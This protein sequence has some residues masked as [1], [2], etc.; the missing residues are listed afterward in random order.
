MKNARPQR[1]SLVFVVGNND[2][3]NFHDFR[4]PAAA[5]TRRGVV[6]GLADIRNRRK[7]H[8][9]TVA[10]DGTTPM[11]CVFHFQTLDAPTNSHD[12]IPSSLRSLTLAMSSRLCTTTSVILVTT[13]AVG[14]LEKRV[15]PATA[16]HPTTADLSDSEPGTSRRARARCGDQSLTPLPTS[17]L[18]PITGQQPHL[19]GIQ[20]RQESASEPFFIFEESANH[21]QRKITT[22]QLVERLKLRRHTPSSAEQSVDRILSVGCHGLFCPFRVVAVKS[23]QSP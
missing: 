18:C 23:K 9:G 19:A 14:R 4:P 8:G 21:R 22:S 13:G 7:D 3:V 5:G 16:L 11:V 12:A 2:L 15:E 6:R 20:H 10:A 17:N 1:A